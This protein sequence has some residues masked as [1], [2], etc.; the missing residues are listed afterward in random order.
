M[1]HT[2]NP[3]I[4]AFR[5]ISEPQKQALI[6]F[7]NAR[8]MGE[9]KGRFTNERRKGMGKFFA[10]FAGFW[11]WSSI[12]KIFFFSGDIMHDQ[13]ENEILYWKRRG[14]K[15]YSWYWFCLIST[16]LPKHYTWCTLHCDPNE[17]QANFSLSKTERLTL[18]TAKWNLVERGTT[19]RNAHF[20]LPQTT[21]AFLPLPTEKW[22]RFCGK[23]MIYKGETLQGLYG[24][25]IITI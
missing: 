25:I 9:C 17:F 14:N 6:F 18:V 21:V 5:R 11:F 22:L 20:E 19:Q 23:I 24:R 12:W 15:T 7:I 13:H 2:D 1:T 10:Y 16:C 4:S 8:A 3:Q